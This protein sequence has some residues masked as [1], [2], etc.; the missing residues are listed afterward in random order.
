MTFGIIFLFLVTCCS[1]TYG[2][3]PCSGDWELVYHA[4]SGNG[5]SFMDTWQ[6]KFTKKCEPFTDNCQCYYREGCLSPKLRMETLGVTPRK[7]LRSP[8]IDYWNCLNIKRVRM[9]LNKESKTVAFI[10]FNG[11][12][13]NY[14]NWFHRGRVLKS[15]WIDLRRN[16]R[17]NFFSMKKEQRHGRHFFINKSYGGCPND[18]GWLVVMDA[19]GSKPC[20]W[21]KQ[22]RYP[23]FL[24]SKGNK[25]GRWRSMR[26]GKADVLNIYIKRG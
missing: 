12:G 24:Y 5:Q 26:Y 22:R 18:K 20:R 13:S 16:G 6:K 11:Q 17:F 1:F 25:Y 3:T 7:I 21:E 9:E 14:M 19:K 8:K 15:S 10:E 4:V 23:Q 2:L